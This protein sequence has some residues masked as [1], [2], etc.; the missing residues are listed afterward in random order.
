MEETDV[1]VV[2]MVEMVETEGMIIEEI[3]VM[4]VTEMNVLTLP[5]V[6]SNDLQG[7]SPSARR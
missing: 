1:T 3:H 5:L 4:D 2:E 7:L 6:T